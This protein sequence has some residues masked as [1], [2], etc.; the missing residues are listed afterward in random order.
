[1]ARQRR[2]LV[3]ATLL[4]EGAASS[5]EA[6]REALA[7]RGI[8]VTQATLSRDLRDLGTVKTSEGYVLAE[9]FSAPQDAAQSLARALAEHVIEVRVA[10]QMIV[11]KTGPG[12]AQIVAVELDRSPLDGIA[13][14]V[15]GDD[16][17]FV[18]GTSRASAPA[19]ADR[20]RR[21]MLG[22]PIGLLTS[23]VGED[24]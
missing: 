21:A 16:T 14:T 3:I 2:Q 15:A 10:E 24:H 13:G 6:L 9:S 4:R 1:M 20:I 19:V 18:C 17:I 7:E 11:L 22:E 5:Q 12:R 8:E 23:A